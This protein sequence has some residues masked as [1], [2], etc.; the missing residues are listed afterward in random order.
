[1]KENIKK[2]YLETIRERKTP[3]VRDLCRRANIN[4]S[5]FYRY[6]SCLEAFEDE[7]YK[8]T[9]GGL[10]PLDKE[11]NWE[12][13]GF[14]TSKEIHNKIFYMNG[15][16][17]IL[18]NYKKE[19][20]I[21]YLYDFSCLMLNKHQNENIKEKMYLDF[22]FYGTINIITSNKYSIEDKESF[23]KYVYQDYLK[24]I[25]SNELL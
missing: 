12:I 5:T 10:F 13:E 4:K 6:Y 17:K 16:V 1:M 15:D 22:Y 18:F 14:E 7:L 23:I 20:F 25:K 9:V 2:A 11:I 24:K 8:E 21:K 19:T 3:N